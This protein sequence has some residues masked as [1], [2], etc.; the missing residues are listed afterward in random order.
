M[1]NELALPDTLTIPIVRAFAP[2]YCISVGEWL[3][4]TAKPNAR[5][6]TKLRTIAGRA[7]MVYA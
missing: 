4:R 7:F 5:T 1:T 6:E 2:A 3:P